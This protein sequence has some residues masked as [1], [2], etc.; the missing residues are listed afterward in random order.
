MSTFLNPLSLAEYL[1]FFLPIALY[2]YFHDR[3]VIMKLMSGLT[4]I[5]SFLNIWLTQSRGALVVLLAMGIAYVPMYYMRRMNRQPKRT[6]LFIASVVLPVVLILVLVSIFMVNE[7]IA[8]RSAKETLSSAYRF[9]QM[10]IGV[11]LVLERP[12]LG[13]GIGEAASV[14]G[15]IS[16]TVDNYYLT[17]SLESGL[18]SLF[19]L[20][21]I[22]SWFI[23]Q[24][25]STYRTQFD[26]MGTLAG[27]LSIALIG[28]MIFLTVLSLKQVFPVVFLVFSML[29]ALRGISSSEQAQE[30]I[31]D[32]E[33]VQ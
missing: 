14:L 23:K 22:L 11:P 7:F 31:M 30:G 4:I 9:K 13:Y 27:A 19:L 25:Y 5:M 3:S 12:I 16:K 18:P 17:V 29:L 26:D 2:V 21:Y 28:F 6:W 24:G 20:L 1:V 10:Q 33:A 32:P 8:G 15:F